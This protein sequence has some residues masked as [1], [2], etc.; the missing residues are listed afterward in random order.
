MFFG[1]LALLVLVARTPVSFLSSPL[2]FFVQEETKKKTGGAGGGVSLVMCADPGDM[3]GFG[4]AQA[5]LEAAEEDLGADPK[6]L[7]CV[8]ARR[9][10]IRGS[11]VLLATTGI[12]ATRAALCLDSVLQ[13]YGSGIE[14][15]IFM[16]TAGG[17]PARGGLLKDCQI[18]DEAD[19]VRLGDVCVSPF[20][21]NWDCQKCF[22][23]REPYT[24]AAAID[25][26]A[27]AT[28]PCSLHERWDLFGDFAC[29]FYVDVAL[30]DEILRAVEV[31]AQREEEDQ[32]HSKQ[33][34]RP[35]AI[36][37]LEDKFW[38]G[39]RH[40]PLDPSSSPRVWNYS[41]C[42]EAT[43]TTYWNGAPYDDLARGYVAELINLSKERLKLDVPNV[44][45][46]DVAAFSA[47]EGTGWMSVV[48][49]SEVYLQYPELPSA[50]V[51][52]VS[53]YT[54]DPLVFDQDSGLWFEDQNWLS[55][56]QRRN[57]TRDGYRF[58]IQS[59]SNVVLALFDARRRTRQRGGEKKHDRR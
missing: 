19:P 29:S 16:G 31:A 24:Q 17:S 59:T 20:A 54:H 41:V 6:E 1:A 47:M 45:R 22:W 11:K 58:A 55:H 8:S 40:H 48:K 52:G 50:N 27:C 49:L 14:E 18:H 21:T 36:A 53:D 56:D 25:A 32:D 44:T 7:L 35:R 46:N 43:A 33:P 39:T 9:L 23:S 15:V 26:S 13:T 51:R 10:V 37:E 12:G 3:I 4:E 57:A 30:S 42:A 5:L 2:S 28:A 38:R 34:R